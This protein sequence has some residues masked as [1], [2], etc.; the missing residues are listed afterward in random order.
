MISYVCVSVCVLVQNL[1][2]GLG[3]YEEDAQCRNKISHFKHFWTVNYLWIIMKLHI[4]ILFYV[5]CVV[6]VG[7]KH[8]RSSIKHLCCIKCSSAT[9]I[10]YSLRKWIHYGSMLISNVPKRNDVDT[11]YYYFFLF[12]YYYGCYFLPIRFMCSRPICSFTVFINALTVNAFRFVV[13]YSIYSSSTV[14]FSGF[15]YVRIGWKIRN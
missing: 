9:R 5:I 4:S 11:A 14:L 15:G 6:D 2:L 10:F 8:I 12:Y 13:E 3:V 7:Y 1:S